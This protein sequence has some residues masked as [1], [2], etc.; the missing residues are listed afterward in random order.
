M[1]KLKKAVDGKYLIGDVQ[2]DDIEDAAVTLAKLVS[3]KMLYTGVYEY[4][5]YDRSVYA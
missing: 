5:E 4:A 3:A 2:T 1:A